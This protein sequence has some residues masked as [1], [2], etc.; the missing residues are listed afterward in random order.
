MQ[1]NGMLPADIIMFPVFAK[2]ECFDTMLLYRDDHH[3]FQLSTKVTVRGLFARHP[4]D[5]TQAVINKSQSRSQS[6][7]RKEIRCISR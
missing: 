7:F 4:A 3:I 1:Y 5:C 2:P 6:S